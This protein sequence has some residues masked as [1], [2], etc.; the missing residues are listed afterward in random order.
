MVAWN[1]RS[2][3]DPTVDVYGCYGLTKRETRQAIPDA[4]HAGNSPADT[5]LS[6]NPY[7][8]RRVRE[9]LS[10]TSSFTL[11]YFT[12]P[13]SCSCCCVSC[14]YKILAGCGGSVSLLVRPMFT[15]LYFTVVLCCV[16]L[17]MH[18]CQSTGAHRASARSRHDDYL[19]PGADPT[20]YPVQGLEL[21]LVEFSNGAHRASAPARSHPSSP[22]SSTGR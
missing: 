12:L 16:G 15:L 6:Q 19:R 8:V 2:V 22:Q 1:G 3:G 10:E 13:L 14:C 18:S 4:H 17:I 5:P 9:S 20:S 11:L 7:G 21:R